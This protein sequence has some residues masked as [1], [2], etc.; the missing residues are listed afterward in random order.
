MPNNIGKSDWLVPGTPAYIASQTDPN[1]NRDLLGNVIDPAMEPD[2]GAGMAPPRDPYMD[3][4]P[5]VSAQPAAQP[6][7]RL[8]PGRTAPFSRA[9]AQ[10]LAALDPRAL[11]EA[12][13]VAAM[14]E[15]TPA[16]ITGSFGGK[17]FEMQPSARVDRNALARLYQQAETRKAQERTDDVRAQEQGGRERIV[18]IPGQQMT[19]REKLRIAAEAEALKN[20][21]AFEAPE[22]DVR[23]ASG[24]SAINIA[25]QEAGRKGQEFAERVT[26]EQQAIDAAYEK[27]LANPFAATPEGR[28]A[29]Q[30]LQ[31]QTTAGKRLPTDTND[32]V[33]AGASPTPD[34]GTIAAEVM[35]DPGIS[36]LIENA[37][38]SKP[39][40]FTGSQGRA[41]GTASRLLAERAIRAR[42]TKGGVPPEE[43]D[44]FVTSILGPQPGAGNSMGPAIGA[45]ARAFPGGGFV[46]SALDR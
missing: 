42:L 15:S 28:A 41:T 36:R 27:A 2:R 16:K 35:A 3:S 17:S 24:Q 4:L 29:I 25:G 13:A 18:S 20:K 9:D 38:K 11:D 19:E 22:R 7:T 45:A 32:A 39:G 46:A 26:P 14:P 1:R 37:Q 10:A 31:P 33:A 43:A 44:A 34:L 40:T 23:V 5:P 8:S 21:Q 30:R 6:V 12:K